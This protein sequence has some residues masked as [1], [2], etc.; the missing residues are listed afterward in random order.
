M[1]GFICA[2]SIAQLVDYYRQ[3][4]ALERQGEASLSDREFFGM[5]REKPRFH[6][7]S[8]VA[9][10]WAE[11]LS[12]PAAQQALVQARGRESAVVLF[13]PYLAVFAD[14]ESG[15]RRWEPVGGVYCLPGPEGTRVDPADLLLGRSLSE[16]ISVEDLIVVRAQLEH[17]A[18]ESPLA[19]A[20]TVRDLLHQ[21]GLSILDPTSLSEA[22]PPAIVAQA[23]FWVIGEATYDRALL[24]ELEQLRGR[25]NAGTALAFL[26]GPPKPG[27]PAFEDVLTA[28]ANPIAPT[29]SQAMALA[30]AMRQPVTVITG[31]PGTG[32]TRVIVGLIIHH[33]L[34]GRSLL[35]ASRI[36]RA[37]DAA[38]ELA[39]R[40][41]GKGCVLRTG[42]E[43]ARMQLARTLGELADRS[44]WGYEGELFAA[45]LRDRPSPMEGGESLLRAAENELRSHREEFVRLC[46]QLNRKARGLRSFGFGPDEGWWDG[47]WWGMRWQLLGKRRWRDFQATWSELEQL[48]EQADRQTLPAAR[49][50][51]TL[52]LWARLND[53][54]QRSRSTLREAVAALTD[55]R[56]RPKA[57]EQLARLGFPIAVTTL[58]TGQNLPLSAGVF[59][60]LVVDEASSCDPASLLPLLYRAQ[61]VVIVG[62]PKQLDH[63]TRERWKRVSPVPQL[64]SV[65]GKLVEASFGVS[66]F[67]LAHQI[68]GGETFWLTDHFRCPPPIIAFANETFYGGRLHIHT[69]WKER[70]PVLVQRVAGAHRTRGATGSLTNAEQL[71]AAFRILAEW[72][73]RYPDETLGLVSPYR[74]F[75]DDALEHLGAEPV[76]EDLRKK[77]ESQH[78]IIGT[79]HRFQGS[80]V[81][82]LVFATVAGDNAGDTISG[83]SSIRTCSMSPSRE[84]GVSSF[85]CSAPNSRGDR[86]W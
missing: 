26:F 86:F 25:S 9:A 31:P 78:L 63:V 64:Q 1:S 73:E 52:A 14:M 68:G 45:L 6:P 24:E 62:D 80:E 85:C 36:N 34:S 60:T 75:I 13:A 2:T 65:A 12:T 37:V 66:A 76:F 15:E 17:A 42:N 77:R 57:F 53:L 48:L 43:Q 29:L 70:E 20:R 32:K 59:D 5:R 16:E 35:L 8:E 11:M 47:L 50:A 41:M 51:Y 69:E 46:L 30:A 61:R 27:R 23:G 79:A 55:R 67:A 39:E 71:R 84:R 58:S 49:R 44:R 82:R 33:L 21:R 81:D 40:L 54:L 56:A 83:G 19:L 74:A 22:R 10:T 3:C 38:V 7:V 18:R 72:A 28:L 4:L